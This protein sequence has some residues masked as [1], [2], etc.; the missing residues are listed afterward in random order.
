V[1]HP[2]QKW[3]FTRLSSSAYETHKAWIRVDQ[4]FKGTK[5]EEVFTYSEDEGNC[6]FVFQDKDT[7][8]QWLFYARRTSGSGAVHLGCSR[9][10]RLRSASADLLF[11][12]SLPDS[13]KKNR[14][15]GTVSRLLDFHQGNFDRAVPVS[16]ITIAVVGELTN[17]EIRTDANGVFELTDL[18]PGHYGVQVKVSNSD[19]IYFSYSV[20]GAA[21][22]LLQ[23]EIGARMQSVQVGA[24]DGIEVDFVLASKAMAKSAKSHP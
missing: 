7:Q 21:Q 9:T 13:D 18:V 15:S 3:G 11:L 19:L 22:R 23:G 6:S 12:R 14:L 5:A 2:G 8:G 1:I 4:E 20:G 10:T 16:G 24:D 17:Q